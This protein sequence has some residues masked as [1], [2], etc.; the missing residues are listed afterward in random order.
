LILNGGEGAGDRLTGEN[1]RKLLDVVHSSTLVQSQQ[2]P[3]LAVSGVQE[4]LEPLEAPPISSIESKP[5][6][7]NNSN[8]KL[9]VSSLSADIAQ[10]A[11]FT[12]VDD[13]EDEDNIAIS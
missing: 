7:A 1:L 11:G 6:S 9:N 8:E 12:V 3:Q 5:N 10:E 13:E 2:Q 4:L